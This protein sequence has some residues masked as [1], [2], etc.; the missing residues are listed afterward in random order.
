ML[1]IIL[2]IRDEDDRNYVENVYLEQGKKLYKIACTYLNHR[3]DSE[4]CVHDVI[5]ALINKLEEYREWDR[6]HQ[7]NFLCKCCRCIAIN[8]YNKKVNRN[9]LETSITYEDE[10]N[11]IKDIDIPDDSPDVQNII[12]SEENIKRISDILE[13]MD[14]MYGD[15]LYLKSFL[16]MK[17]I[18]IAKM[19]K[20]NVNLVNVR[21]VRAR[22][23]L[24]E[25]YGAE[26]YDIRTK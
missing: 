18:E 1:P 2:A 17:N 12:I 19:L 10:N 4:D 6:L 23:I 8:K 24:M 14:P 7:I 20:I 13:D 21:V 3:Q 5:V 22:K 9:S 16:G 15:I 11:E 25:R 26:L